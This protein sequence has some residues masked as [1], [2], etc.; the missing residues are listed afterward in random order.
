MHVGNQS[1]VSGICNFGWYEWVHYRD[2]GSFPENKQKLKRII[3][4]YNNKSNGMPQSIVT[5]SGHAMNLQTVR[6]LRTS[7][8]HSEHEKK[9]QRTFHD[10]ILN[11][12]GDYCSKL[13]A[14]DAPD[15]VPYSNG[16]DQDST[17]MPDDD[18]P[19]MPDGTIIFEKPATDQWTHVELNLHQRELL[20]KS[21]VIS[22]SKDVNG[23]IKDL[24]DPNIF[25]ATFIYDVEFPN[26]E[27]KECSVN[28]AA[29]NTH[30]PADDD[31]YAM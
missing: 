1:D 5:S 20:R 26:G 27:I 25:L 21:K 3:G 15:H 31:G 12:L 9:E 16:V 10:I 23:E 11:K 17:Q 22:L 8:L 28:F 4:P 24:H 19:I 30:S 6:S 18:N 13:T 2:H 14:P 7:E 29:Q